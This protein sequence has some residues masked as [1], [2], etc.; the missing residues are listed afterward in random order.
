MA[1][2]ER[3]TKEKGERGGRV[4]GVPLGVY[5]AAQ[6][7]EA[8]VLVPRYDCFGHTAL[9]PLGLASVA[10]LTYGLN[11]P[12][13]PDRP[14]SPSTTFDTCAVA[15]PV[16]TAIPVPFALR[17]GIT[18]HLS[19]ECKGASPMSL[20]V[21]MYC[22]GPVLRLVHWHFVDGTCNRRPV[23]PLLARNTRRTSD[24]LPP[25]TGRHH[26]HYRHNPF[27]GLTRLDKLRT[28]DVSP[29][30]IWRHVALWL[31]SYSA[32]ALQVSTTVYVGNE[33]VAP[34]Y[35]CRLPLSS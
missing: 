33:R 3:R 20:V 7:V 25:A 2:V 17:F 11:C 31:Q 28:G 14:P 5:P 30:T 21:S 27:I 19:L 10:L 9:L 26:R 35:G 34:A 29:G 8:D 15:L 4:T 18:A 24:G 22:H 1:D 12:L 13:P 32:S 6:S 23:S 16:A